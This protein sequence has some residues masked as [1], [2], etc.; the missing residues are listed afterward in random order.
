MLWE[1]L[2]Y[3]LNCLRIG[4]LGWIFL[5]GSGLGGSGFRSLG[6]MSICKSQVVKSIQACKRGP[7]LPRTLTKVAA[8]NFLGT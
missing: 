8:P 7:A 5:Q 2:H 1:T 6:F 3:T 4:S